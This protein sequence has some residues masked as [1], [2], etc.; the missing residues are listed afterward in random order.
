MIAAVKSGSGKTLITCGLLFA[1]KKRGEHPAAWKTGPDYIDPMFHQTV[2]GVPS[3]N[4]DTYFSAP[5]TIRALYTEDEKKG[6][7]TVIE[8]VM[9]LY[10]GLSGIREEGS[11]YDLARTLGT[12]IILVIDAHG[13]GRSVIPVL[14]GILQYDTS[15]LI[16]GVI[17]NRTTE[18]F[19]R[20]I[21][22]LIEQELPVQV[23]GCFPAQK[24]IHLE[25]RHLGLRL[26]AEMN[27]LQEQVRLAADVLEHNVAV[28]EIIKIAGMAE[29]PKP[30]A[31]APGLSV[32]RIKDHV[33]IGVARDEAFC[34][35]YEDNL[36]LL[37]KAGAELVFFSPLHDRSLPKEIS[38]LILYGG[39][40]EL[41]A[42]A[43]SENQSMRNAVRKAILQG[44]P[45]IAE[46][47]GFMYLHNEIQDAEGNTYPMC[48]VIP[49]SCRNQGHL[50]RFGYVELFEKE[51]NFLGEQEGI[52]GHE[53]HYYDST[54]NGT[55]CTARKPVTGR[56]WDC[57][58]ENHNQW[59]GF[60]HLYYPSNLNFVYHFLE[61][62]GNYTQRDINCKI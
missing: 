40:P 32:R 26:P 20:S 23:L 31:S 36:R 55:S 59:F 27:H 2:I 4:L 12:P 6:G 38:G 43:L 3:R 21:A 57:I 37:R 16:K 28:D 5:D 61:A 51:P 9:G 30:E 58:I 47:G 7:I 11:S 35:M 44:M 39:Y 22:P 60:P 50:V 42:G 53:F 24:E 19:C 34:F 54:V 1:L 52:K 56:S 48:G 46:C 33:R 15:R 8:G 49:G 41:C 10:D 13:M 14:A 17:L 45:C 25:S 29:V 62:A 18:H